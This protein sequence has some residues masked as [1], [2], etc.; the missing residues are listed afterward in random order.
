MADIWTRDATRRLVRVDYGSEEEDA[1]TDIDYSEEE[2][3]EEEDFRPAALKALDAADVPTTEQLIGVL[4][5]LTQTLTRITIQTATI[6]KLELRLS[7]AYRRSGTPI[8]DVDIVRIKMREGKKGEGRGTQLFKNLMR[9]AATINRGV[10][11]EQCITDD[12]RAWGKRL[13]ER[14]LAKIQYS[15]TPDPSYLSIYP[16][17]DSTIDED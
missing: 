8:L 6:E 5:L 13:E 3:E 10:F 11:L 4:K 7:R 2:E 17:S 1:I 9:A 14:G 16:L 15:Y 12:S